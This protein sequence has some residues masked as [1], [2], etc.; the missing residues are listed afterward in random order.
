MKRKLIFLP[1]LMIIL[2]VAASLIAGTIL[3]APHREQIGDVPTYLKGENIALSSASGATLRGWFLP[4]KQ[5]AGAVVLMHGVRASRTAML[6]HATFL[7]RAGYSILLFDFQAHGES[8]GDHI[9][10][11][12][13][14]S[15]M[16]R[17]P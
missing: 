12:Q 17:Q 13:L 7:S 5:G 6:G 14:E 15:K 8:T 1:L 3:S 11:G 9:T 2:I 10:F 4:G 16:R